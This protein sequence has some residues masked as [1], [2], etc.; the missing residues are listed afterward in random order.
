MSSVHITLF[1]RIVN[2][3]FVL[4]HWF[5]LI[6]AFLMS[7]CSG[8]ATKPA[9]NI[10]VIVPQSIA[11]KIVDA[12]SLKEYHRA[13]TLIDNGQ[14]AEADSLLIKVV[15][16]YP[17]LAAPLYNLGVISESQKD[18][19]GAIGFYNR[20][21]EVDKR[22]Y[23]AYNNLGVIAR[24][25]GEFDQA[26]NYYRNGLSI[27]PDNPE[28]HYNMAVLNELYLHD[29]KKAI[30]HYERYLATVNENGADSP[31]KNVVSWIK[32]LKRRS[33]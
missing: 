13:I 11:P 9:E 29:Y 31:D 24:S 17:D 20:A 27:A 10:Q 6:A 30:D 21:I 23:L 16:K 1:T 32:D 5:V 2:Q 12:V 18:L 14:F 22:Y 4:K 7:A 25:Q 33:R 3:L 28:L 15:D 19:N 26:L 8:V